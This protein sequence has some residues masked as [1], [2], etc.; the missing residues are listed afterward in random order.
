MKKPILFFILFI[1][2]VGIGAGTFFVFKEIEK[3]KA[4]YN[5]KLNSTKFLPVD[6]PVQNYFLFDIGVTDVNQ[7][8]IFDIFTTNHNSK[9]SLLIGKGNGVF[10]PNQIDDYGLGQNHEYHNT[11]P[12][13]NINRF[14][15]PGIY[16]YNSETP[17]GLAIY[18][19]GLDQKLRGEISCFTSNI[20]I[21][22]KAGMKVSSSKTQ[23]NSK[24][25]K[26]KL[27]F[28]C[29]DEGL[30][31]LKYDPGSHPLNIK[32]DSSIRLNDIYIGNSL[33]NPQSHEI[34][35]IL[36]DRHAM[37]WSDY[38]KDGIQDVFIARG[39]LKHKLK[40]YPL[41]LKDE[42]FAGTD[43]SFS[44]VPDSMIFSKDG[45]SGR[46]A[47][48]IDINNDSFNDLYITCS[49]GENLLLIQD[50]TGNFDEAAE[51][52][53][54]GF[55]SCK[56]LKWFDLNSD[57]Y[58]DLVFVD[59]KQDKIQIWVNEKQHFSLFQEISCK[60]VKDIDIIDIDNDLDFD[61][62]VTSSK[63]NLLLEYNSV[64]KNFKPN[65]LKNQHLPSSGYSTTFLDV[66]NDGYTDVYTFPTGL[67][68]FDPL[69]N[70]F[71]NNNELN[72]S[73]PEN[74]LFFNTI[75][76][77]PDFNN[78]GYRDALIAY[79][80]RFPP[81]AGYG[82]GFP[83]SN[84][85]DVKTFL[86]LNIPT[87][88]NNW[89]EVELTGPQNTLNPFGTKVVL[90][91]NSKKQ[92]QF[93]GQNENSDYSQGDFRLYFGLGE[94]NEATLEVYWNN[95]EKTIFPIKKVNQFL[96]LSYSS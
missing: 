89:L 27:N 14:N 61:I 55:Y 73:S 20:R 56:R 95:G 8:G 21:P 46:Q 62:F 86:F 58:L 85:R 44:A 76:I 81:I 60:E 33:I 47:M 49:R 88:K 16:I 39:G 26:F 28:T 15:K 57:R 1:I 5:V 96:K 34:E 78:D 74:S 45:C 80:P 43:S 7:D 72:I 19:I 75:A 54:I 70:Q 77:W 22:Y 3:I 48:W 66:N 2:L 59:E 37:A 51:K 4:Y 84:Y 18:K 9:Q 31:F 11:E 42:L 29:Q 35:F 90:S 87:Q 6:F 24:F 32:I 64:T 41:D 30:L 17:I 12:L 50:S 92:V 83:A 38:N 82:F 40:D 69:T 13:K 68:K 63:K 52:F 67:F 65:N 94:E 71:S 25:S 93:I 91:T 23:I 36:R 79:T 10:Y 53:N